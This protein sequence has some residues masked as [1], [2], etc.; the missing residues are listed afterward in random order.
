MYGLK[1]LG[2]NWKTGG[3]AVGAPALMRGPGALQRSGK[4]SRL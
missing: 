4:D 3:F 2:E 1:S